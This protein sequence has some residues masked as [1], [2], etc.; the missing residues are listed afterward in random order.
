MLKPLAPDLSRCFLLAALRDHSIRLFHVDRRERVEAA[1]LTQWAAYRDRNG[2]ADPLATWDRLLESAASQGERDAIKYLLL[3]V[4]FAL[5][6]ADEAAPVAALRKRVIQMIAGS[7]PHVIHRVSRGIGA[8][9][10]A[11]AGRPDARALLDLSVALLQAMPRDDAAEW[12]RFVEQ[13]LK[14]L[15]EVVRWIPSPDERARLIAWTRFVRKYVLMGDT[16]AER[17][18]GLRALVA[19]NAR[20]RKFLDALIYQ[21]QLYHRRHDLDWTATIQ[22]E[23]AS[24]HVTERLVIAVGTDGRVWFFNRDGLL[25]NVH[26]HGE[27]NRLLAAALVAEEDGIV[28]FAVSRAKLMGEPAELVV[29]TLPPGEVTAPVRVIE[30]VV[31]TSSVGEGVAVHGMCRLPNEHCVLLAGLNKPDLLFGLIR[32]GNDGWRLEGVPRAEGGGP[33]SLPPVDGKL[34]PDE[35]ASRAVAVVAAGDGVYLAVLGSDDGALRIVDFC[36]KGRRSPRVRE[37]SL[38]RAIRS[39]ALDATVD[40]AGRKLGG[41][42]CYV[43][44]AHDVGSSHGEVFVAEVDLHQAAPEVRPAWRETYDQPTL[45]IQVWNRTP[46]YPSAR[47]VVTATD[48]GRLCLYDTRVWTGANA[49][50]L[51]ETNNFFFRGMRLDRV[52]LPAPLT[53]LTLIDGQRDFVAGQPG[54][55][56]LKGALV[57]TRDSIDRAAAGASAEPLWSRLDGL[58][59]QIG[60]GKL[61]FPH[62][63]EHARRERERAIYELVN[64]E[65]SALRRYLLR[66]RLT[67]DE[68]WGDDGDAIRHRAAKLLDGLRPGVAGERDLIKIV[69]KSLAREHLDPPLAPLLAGS[70]DLLGTSIDE[71]YGAVQAAVGV[72]HRQIERA[73]RLPARH[74]GRLRIIAFKELFRLHT[75]RHAARER[76]RGAERPL[77][78]ALQRGLRACLHDEDPLVRSEALRAVGLTL[79]NVLVLCDLLRRA[80]PERAEALRRHL[81]PGGAADVLWMLDL[82]ADWLKHYPSF[83]PAA[84]LS[85]AWYGLSALHP[86]FLLFPAHTLL[87]CDRLTRAGVPTSALEVVAQRLQRGAGRKVAETMDRLYLLSEEAFAVF[88]ADEKRRALQGWLDDALPDVEGAPEGELTPDAKI[89]RRLVRVYNWLAFCWM[90]EDPERIGE[91]P[92]PPREDSVVMAPDGAPRPGGPIGAAELLCAALYNL[93][94]WLRAPRGTDEERRTE[95]ALHA[96]KALREQLDGAPYRLLTAPYRLLTAPVRRIGASILELWGSRLAD[97]PPPGVGALVGGYVLGRR[98]NEGGYGSVHLVEGPEGR[99]AIKVFNRRYDPDGSRKQAFVAG[100]ARSRELSHADCPGIV[101]VHRILDENKRYPAYVMEYCNRKDLAGYLRKKA[102][103]AGLDPAWR[104]GVALSV[105]EQVGAGL[106]HAHGCGI[107]HGDI[108]PSNILVHRLNDHTLQYKLGDFDLSYVSWE[109]VTPELSWAD[110]LPPSVRTRVLHEP[111]PGRLADIGALACVIYGVLTGESLD[112]RSATSAFAEP[113]RKLAEIDCDNAPHLQRLV[114]A[115]RGLWAD[116]SDPGVERIKDA[117]VFLAAITNAP[118][119]SQPPL[120]WVRLSQEDLSRIHE[121]IVTLDLDRDTLLGGIDQAVVSSLPEVNKPNEQL[122]TDLHSLNDCLTHDSDPLSKLLQNARLLSRGRPEGKVFDEMLKRRRGG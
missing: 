105:A 24:L 43:G 88:T 122:L 11:D 64:L 3:D 25:L 99:V 32:R 46:L 62:L 80:S 82:V 47:V 63:D 71:K 23:V 52:S 79:R 92:E 98:L 89:A 16:F 20:N 97:T 100:A 41:F 109:H 114:T 119:P 61:F 22:G 107:V 49:P 35:G 42:T 76:E 51:S 83:S 91:L 28:H 29:L 115:L 113:C 118:A 56:I 58:H 45:A 67:D 50:E 101:R 8:F 13:H 27:G 31:D 77:D 94:P 48:R 73:A 4:M 81:F 68:P 104:Y 2:L 84:V 1:V 72:L 44:T 74:A 116:P 108:K 65:G 111:A 103:G 69:L 12:S 55:R 110:V 9:A 19:L 14:A 85:F 112:P 59:A 60:I 121:T 15:S 34:L 6:E 75:L 53:C 106:R 21:A 10:G 78:E 38:L 5:L 70:A 17:T 26:G 30:R 33:T 57:C 36:V 18:R 90:L 66:R 54:G 95:E 120:N 40:A 7:S 102:E 86:L 39:V 93:T 87:F 117:E 37:H 96:V